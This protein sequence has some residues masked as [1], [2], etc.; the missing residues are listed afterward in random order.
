MYICTYI[1]HMYT[2]IHFLP[3]SLNST[4][5]ECEESLFINLAHLVKW[6]DTPVQYR[7]KITT[8]E[9]RIRVKDFEKAL[10]VSNDCCIILIH[11][12]FRSHY[13]SYV[14]SR[15]GAR[16]CAYKHFKHLF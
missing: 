11:Q 3:F 4:F 9:I 14:F 10:E 13:N 5:T 2:C 12:Y 6:V 8:D 7:G 1:S 16:T 15:Y